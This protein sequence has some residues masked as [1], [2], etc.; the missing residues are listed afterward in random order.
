MSKK[1]IITGGAG[2]IG[3]HVTDLMVSEGYDVTVFDDLSTGVR[4]N[5]NKQAKFIKIDITNFKKLIF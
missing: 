4:S 3:S 2:F 1:V 5:I